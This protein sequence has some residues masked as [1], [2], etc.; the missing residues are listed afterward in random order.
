MIK[1]ELQQ[2]NKTHAQNSEGVEVFPLNHEKLSTSLE[3]SK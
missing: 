3:P 1:T 2:K